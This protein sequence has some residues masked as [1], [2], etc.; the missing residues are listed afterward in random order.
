MAPT[1]PSTLV[2]KNTAMLC[3]IFLLSFVGSALAAAIPSNGT[4]LE[5]LNSTQAVS[6]TQAE[7]SAAQTSTSIS[8]AQ[9]SQATRTA[10]SAQATSTQA[11]NATDSC[12]SAELI[13]A[14]GTFEKG[15]GS[16]GAPLAAGLAVALPG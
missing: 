4:Q 13:F 10:Q 16:V 12:A 9:Y 11:T 14:A 3:T 15:W 8:S 7:S 6:S 2:L 1:I 5:V